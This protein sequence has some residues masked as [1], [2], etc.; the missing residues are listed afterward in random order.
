MDKIFVKYKSPIAII[1]LLILVLGG[2]AYK[3]LNTSLFPNVTF[4]KIKIIADNG[5]QPVDKMMV[6]VTKPLENAIKRVENLKLIR[7]VTSMGSC[8][9]SAFMDWGSDIDVDKQ[10]L[11]SRINQIKNDL[12]PNVQIT[13]EKMNPSILPVMGYSL[14]SDTKNQ[15][16]LKMIGEYI[17]KPYLSRIDGVAAVEVIGGKT[18]EYHVILNQKKLS[19]LK[20]TPQSIIDAI[21][22]TGFIKSNGYTVDYK[23]LY[24]TVTDASIKNKKQLENLVIFDD[25]KRK[26]S[27]K[28]IAD[29]KISEKT[30]Y[31]KIN[32]DGKNVPLIAVLKQP[33]SNLIKVADKV[34]RDVTALNKIL[35]KG[36]QLVK[37]YNQAEFV[38]DS[39]KSI[40]DVLWIGLLLAIVVVMIFLRSLKASSVLLVTIPVTLGLTFLIM[41]VLGYDL[42]IMTI[43]AIAAAIG[44]IIDDAVIIVEQIHRTH[45]EFPKEKPTVLVGKAIKFLF[46][47]MISSSLST[48]VI[49]LPFILMT[50]VAGAYFKILTQT[51][52]ITLAVSFLVTWLGLPVIYLLFSKKKPKEIQVHHLKERKWVRFFIERPVFSYVFILLSILSV[53]FVLPKLKTGFLPQMD[54]GSIILDYNSPPGTS[55]EETDRMLSE[56]DAILD[57]IPEVKAYSRRTGTQMGF[58]ITEPNRGDYLIELKKKRNKTT[59]EVTDDIRLKVEASIPALTVDFGQ[60]I[61]DM[62]GDLMSSVQPIEIKIFGTDHQKL[63][64]LSQ[65]V[66]QKVENVKGTADVFDGIVI[67][68]PMLQI[69]PK[70]NILKQYG[71]SANDL[72]MQIQ[73]YLDGTVAGSILEKEQLTDIRVLQANYSKI[74]IERL[75]RAKIAIKTGDYLPLSTFADFTMKGGVSEIER[76][77]LQSMGVV[78][79]RLN[80]RDLGSVMKD[81]KTALAQIQLPPSYQIVYGGSYAEQQK[82]FNELLMILIL[83]G[84]L[85]FI[86]ILFMFRHFL[87]SLIVIFISVLGISG[88]VLALYLTHTPLNVGSYTGIIMII[89]IL[90]E[91]SIFTIYLFL[92]EIKKMGKEE[93]VIYSISARLRPKLMTAIS[94]IVALT[95][96]ALGIGTGAQMHQPL[97]I[98]VIGGFVFALPL[99]LIVLP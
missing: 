11:E 23:R 9:I 51:M 5:S 92:A 32:A 16:E 34:S 22:Q 53:V 81:I 46:P 48:I 14:Q 95:P 8:E 91:A 3:T 21:Q 59:E 67:A 31:I 33:N 30:E 12:P 24:L 28:D 88:S 36:V 26:I 39:L 76:E 25:A 49:F 83:G 27:L 72:Q 58:F 7:S 94:A 52:I 43:G 41:K 87:L 85:V 64:E 66:A 54:E 44:L 63:Q 93:A 6:T 13:V 68:G 45:E 86:V 99:L 2:Y 89:G 20:L 47:A 73:T 50:G 71:L 38:G 69:H 80:N 19:A 62:L 29:I 97:A 79:A 56:V 65:L 96:L 70:E 42:N 78:T 4:P 60:V 61:T 18:K 10:R 77:N 82:S 98:A 35:P 90:G 37:Y 15:V 55:L 74:P 75:K 40:I 57:K 84:I 17:V 1:L